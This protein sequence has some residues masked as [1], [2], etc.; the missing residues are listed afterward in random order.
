MPGPEFLDLPARTI[1][2][3]GTGI[4]H[5]IDRGLPLEYC[6]DLLESGGA[7]LDV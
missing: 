3:R 2:P 7:Y 6:A 4:T 1:K 5:V